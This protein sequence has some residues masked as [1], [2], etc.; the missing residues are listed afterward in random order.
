MLDYYYFLYREQLPTATFN[1]DTHTQKPKHT[2][3]KT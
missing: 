3:R 2:D 1:K